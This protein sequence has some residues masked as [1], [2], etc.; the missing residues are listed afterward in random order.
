MGNQRGRGKP[1]PAST[2]EGAVAAY[3]A[4]SGVKQIAA[5]ARIAPCTIYRWLQGEVTGSPVMVA[6][7]RRRRLA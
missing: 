6:G 3:Q 1:Y 7:R 5:R 2:V 4:G